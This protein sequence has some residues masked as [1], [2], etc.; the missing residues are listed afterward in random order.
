MTLDETK[1]EIEETLC[2]SMLYGMTAFD[3][4]NYMCSLGAC[5]IF[6][7]LGTHEFKES[8]LPCWYFPKFD[9]Y[10]ALEKVYQDDYQI[11]INNVVEV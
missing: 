8:N 5:S 9:K 6:E 7:E 11:Q 4:D 2:N 10:L 1:N 3:L